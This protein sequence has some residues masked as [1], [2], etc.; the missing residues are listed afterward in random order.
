[1][2]PPSLSQT[3]ITPLLSTVN[4]TGSFIIFS[5]SFIYPKQDTIIYDWNSNSDLINCI[6]TSCSLPLLD[7][8]L[9]TSYRNSYCLDG[10]LYNNKPI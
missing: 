1:M 6:T 4:A 8:C 9:L 2:E 5:V 7:F 10:A 3:Y